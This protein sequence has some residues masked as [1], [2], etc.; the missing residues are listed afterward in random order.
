M[1]GAEAT[2][3]SSLADTAASPPPAKPP[4][5][6]PLAPER[7]GLQVTIDRR[8]HDK[9]RHAQNLLSHT[10]SPRDIAQVLDRALDALIAQLEKRKFAATSKPRH[11]S[12]SNGHSKNPRHVPAY[13]KRAV[14]NRD[15]GQCTFVSESGRRCE[16]RGLLEFDHIDEVARGGEATVA[17][18]RLRCR[19]HS[20]YGAECTFGA[21][22]MRHKREAAREAAA[23]RPS[24]SGNAP[25]NF[26]PSPIATA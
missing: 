9:L 14:W 24:Y 15:G 5:L 25:S 13:V 18:I 11:G 1:C 3:A 7:F 16:A 17:G 10:V 19:A 22:F 20:Q 12:A 6:A 21:E 2:M 23:R 4:R 26:V 8:T